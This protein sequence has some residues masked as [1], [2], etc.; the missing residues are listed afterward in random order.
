VPV[1]AEASILG[2]GPATLKTKP[3]FLMVSIANLSLAQTYAFFGCA[4]Q[5]SSDPALLFWG[6]II[7]P[8]IG[9]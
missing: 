6:G 9:F 1:L 2:A 3:F 8:T 4:G 7:V 5:Q